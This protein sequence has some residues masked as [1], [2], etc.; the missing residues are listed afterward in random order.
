[1][2][3]YLFIIIVVVKQFL[4]SLEKRYTNLLSTIN[5]TMG[6]SNFKLV[7]LE[8]IHGLLSIQLTISERRAKVDLMN[9]I[10]FS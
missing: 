5:L 10:L 1:M 2:E 6:D 3:K 8:T 9:L 7:T 4:S